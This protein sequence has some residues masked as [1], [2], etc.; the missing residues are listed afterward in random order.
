MAAHIRTLPALLGLWS[1][2]RTEK[3]LYPRPQ[4]ELDMFAYTSEFV[5]IAA[6]AVVTAPVCAAGLAALVTGM[7]IEALGGGHR[8]LELALDSWAWL[9][10][11]A[12]G[13][14][15]RTSEQPRTFVSVDANGEESVAYY[16]NGIVEQGRM[17]SASAELLE[18]LTGRAFN[19]MINP[20][21]GVWL[22]LAG[23]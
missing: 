21:D 10:S 23:T 19:L 3:H 18:A 1:W 15:A 12:E 7:V 20:S 14:A 13:R 17:L 8:L 6:A 9:L 4:S 11:Y 2:H 22:D 5:R 16:I